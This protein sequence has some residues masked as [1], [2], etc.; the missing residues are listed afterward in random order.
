MKDCV[1]VCRGGR[2]RLWFAIICI[3]GWLGEE[4]R[5]DVRD[6][7]IPKIVVLDL[8]FAKNLCDQLYI[9]ICM[10]LCLEVADDAN[11]TYF[12]ILLH[13]MVD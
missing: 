7:D 3:W 4:S 6:V 10:H 2:K 8:G 1:C 13:K 11:P 5:E 12:L 9:Y